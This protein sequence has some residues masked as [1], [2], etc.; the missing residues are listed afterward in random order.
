MGALTG[1]L[2]DDSLIS[3]PVFSKDNSYGIDGNLIFSFPCRTHGSK[4]TIDPSMRP[5]EALWKEV[6]LFRERAH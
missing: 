6:L 2:Q 4:I 1:Q 5:S 3:M